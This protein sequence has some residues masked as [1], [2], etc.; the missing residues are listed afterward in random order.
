MTIN[1]I[2][3]ADHTELALNQVHSI[4][5]QATDFASAKSSANGKAEHVTVDAVVAQ[6]EEIV[7]S[8]FFPHHHLVFSFR[9][10]FDLGDGV[11]ACAN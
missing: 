10:C 7:D 1:V 8:F 3:R 2:K 6:V 5:F 4:P 9:R 11:T